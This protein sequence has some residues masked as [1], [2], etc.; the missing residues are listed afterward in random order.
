[1]TSES[2]RAR[3]WRSDSHSPTTALDAKAQLPADVPDS[4]TEMTPHFRFAAVARSTIAMFMAPN[5]RHACK[6]STLE[7]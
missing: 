6:A 4:T 2:L 7:P 5:T 3:R 1:M